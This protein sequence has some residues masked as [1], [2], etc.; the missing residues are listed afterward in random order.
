[1]EV[2]GKKANFTATIRR[3]A[4]WQKGPQRYLFAG[5]K[6]YFSEAPVPNNVCF[7]VYFYSMLATSAFC[8]VLKKLW[9]KVG[10]GIGFT[11]SE[12]NI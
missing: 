2:L 9:I 3:P 1:M 10:P 12:G 11:L 8:K 6:S 7:R 4:S 5:I